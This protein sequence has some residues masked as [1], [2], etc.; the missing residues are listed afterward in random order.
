MCASCTVNKETGFVMTDQFQCNVEGV[1]R[2]TSCLNER[3]TVGNN[4]K[5]P[6]KTAKQVIQGIVDK[7]QRKGLPIMQM[8]YLVNNWK[9]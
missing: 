6:S 5:I 9:Y 7:D 4:L 1:E 3:E 8:S 2:S